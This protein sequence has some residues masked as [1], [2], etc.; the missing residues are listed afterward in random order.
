MSVVPWLQKGGAPEPVAAV[1]AVVGGYGVHGEHGDGHAQRRRKDLRDSKQGPRHVPDQQPVLRPQGNGGLVGFLGA[2][3]GRGEVEGMALFFSVCASYIV[4]VVSVMTLCVG[5]L[6]QRGFKV[7]GVEVFRNR[8]SFCF[9][10]S[11]WI[12]R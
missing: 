2:L 11:S 1:A 9:F 4:E 5:W 10:L 8:Q 6:L 7:C 3:A 12:L